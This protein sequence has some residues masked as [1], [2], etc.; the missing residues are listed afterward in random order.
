MHGET[1]KHT[2]KK[3]GE[4]QI[5]DTAEMAVCL[6]VVQNYSMTKVPSI[7]RDF[8]P[9][10]TLLTTCLVESQRSLCHE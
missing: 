1:L 10:N 5:Y 6:G 8:P 3:N 9:R 2:F 4:E 7:P